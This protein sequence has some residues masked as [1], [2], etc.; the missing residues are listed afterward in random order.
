MIAALLLAFCGVCRF[1]RRSV[2][3][4]LGIAPSRR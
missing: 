4:S 3:R 2:C 1:T